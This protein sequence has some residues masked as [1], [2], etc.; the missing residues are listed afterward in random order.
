MLLHR[1]APPTEPPPTPHP[2]TAGVA[3]AVL[4]GLLVLL[5][6]VVTGDNALTRAD[7]SIVR[8]TAQHRPDGLVDAARAVTLLGHGAI[9]AGLLVVTCVGL[10][11]RG[12]LPPRPALLPPI[13]LAVAGGFNPLWKTL[14][15]RP[16]PPVELR[17]TIEHSSGF[18]SGHASQSASAW[19]ALGL[20]LWLYGRGHPRWPLA[21]AAGLAGAIGVTRVILAVHSPTD[22]LA[23]WCWGTAVALAVVGV[24]AYAE[25]SAAPSTE[26]PA[27]PGSPPASP[28]GDVASA[29]T[30][31]AVNVRCATT[32]G[33]R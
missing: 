3:I 29:S 5:A 12:T 18:P 4:L 32:S 6:V 2:R 28:P 19:I 33:A 10:V 20:V 8:W 16:R 27:P 7:A 17:V 1:A 31:S 9:L 11:L 24:A 26:D 30:P 15:D 14:V 25:R 21:V 23:G 13:A 22:V